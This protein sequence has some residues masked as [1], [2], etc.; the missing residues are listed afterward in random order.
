MKFATKSVQKDSYLRGAIK[1]LKKSTLIIG[2]R[3]AKI[4]E[5]EFLNEV[6]AFL[7]KIAINKK[8]I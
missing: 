3:S 5:M 2:P 8:K 6:D 1:L 7:K 4:N